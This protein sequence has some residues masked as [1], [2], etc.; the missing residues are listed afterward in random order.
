MS[1]RG[2]R[3]ATTAAANT[4]EA[5]AASTEELLVK[6]QS[7][8][9]FALEDLAAALFTVTDDLDA[10]YPARAARGLGWNAVP[11]LCSREIHV[12]GGLARVIRVLLLWNT[13]R[14][15]GGVEHVY[16]GEAR[17][18]RPDLNQGKLP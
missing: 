6:L 14:P 16:L 15:Q 18:L 3:G 7:A 8:N 4:P 17:W 12:P 5:I 9:G 13:D 2:V 11:L 10:D 1:T